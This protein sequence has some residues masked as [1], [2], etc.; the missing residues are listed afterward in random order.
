MI[1]SSSLVNFV[2]AISFYYVCMRFYD[3]HMFQSMKN[4]DTS[5]ASSNVV[6]AGGFGFLIRRIPAAHESSGIYMASSSAVSLIHKP[7]RTGPHFDT[8]PSGAGDLRLS[9]DHCFTLF[10]QRAFNTSSE[11]VSLVG[12]ISMSHDAIPAC[13]SA[14]SRESSFT[15]IDVSCAGKICQERLVKAGPDW[16]VAYVVKEFGVRKGTDPAGSLR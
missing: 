2:C 7:A 12:V 1:W 10:S 9:L 14:A 13:I 11:S 16:N 15:S 4:F 3:F 8:P 5:A 6:A